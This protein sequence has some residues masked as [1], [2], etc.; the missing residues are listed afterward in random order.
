MTYDTDIG[1]NDHLTVLAGFTLQKTEFETNFSR[2]FGLSNDVTGFNNLS[3]GADPTRNQL[4]SGYDSYQLAS[5]LGRINY[6]LNDK[7]LFTLVGRVDGSSRFAPGNKYAFFPS[8][9]F[10]WK[11]SE[12]DFIKNLDVFSDLKLRASY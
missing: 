7:Y 11:L 12:E 3:F 10:A 5:W 6:S 9:A 8:G 1:E 4:G 2:S